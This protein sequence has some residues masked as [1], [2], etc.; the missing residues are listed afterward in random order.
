MRSKAIR[1]FYF[2]II[3]TLGI[4]CQPIEEK[5]SLPLLP[6]ISPDYSGIVIPPNIA[7]LCFSIEE[8]GLHYAVEIRG[9]KGDPIR[10]GS[11][12]GKVQISIKPWKKLLRENRGREIKLFISVLDSSRTWLAFQPIVQRVAQEK[13]DPYLVY[14]RI[15]P[16][17]I[18]WKKI[19]ICERNLENFQERTI[20]FNKPMGE[21]CLNCHSF[22]NYKPDS[23]LVQLR[24]CP[25]TGFLFIHQDKPMLI[26]PRTERV[27]SP[28]VY[29]AWHPSGKYIA[30]SVNK[31]RQF[32]HLTGENRDVIDLVSDLVLYHVDK[33]TFQVFPQ[34]ADPSRLETYPHWSPDG[35]FLYFCSAPGYD[36]TKIFTEAIYKKIRYDLMRVPFDAETGTFGALETVLS[37][38]KMGSSITHPRISP[39]G[40]FLLFCLCDY[41]NF[42]IYQPSSDLYLMDLKT[43]ELRR[44]DVN[45][46]RSESYHAWSSNGRWIVFSSKREDGVCARPYFSYIDTLGN[47]SKPFILPQR[48]PK[49]YEYTIETFN[50]PEFIVTPVQP[51]PQKILLSVLRK[52]PLLHAKDQGA[53]IEMQMP[54]TE[55]SSWKPTPAR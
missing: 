12:N 29:P 37:S 48:D 47:A 49:Y 19:R 7:P 38:Q 9:E 26:D 5:K 27:K 35:K 33:N 44:L 46:P 3:F 53:S 42:S 54:S 28:V 32:F 17:Y 22:L 31:V 21:G 36:T 4:S 50:V 16:L 43:R 6:K 2:I 30:F 20:L 1:C 13:I 52:K 25:V 55:E 23:W 41:G 40:R 11:R 24:K 34:L 8:K 15:P 18:L 39:D 14:R 10:I 51:R 45:S